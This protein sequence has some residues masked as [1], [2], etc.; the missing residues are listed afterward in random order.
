MRYILFTSM[1]A[2][3][4]FFSFQSFNKE[5]GNKVIKREYKIHIPVDTMTFSPDSLY[6]YLIRIGMRYPRI[7]YKQALLESGRFKS[8]LFKNAN[9][10]FGMRMPN[11]RKTTAISK[12][13]GYAKFSCWKHSVDDY[14]LY[15]DAYLSSAKTEEQYYRLLDKKYGA[16]GRYSYT[17]K[18]MSDEVLKKNQ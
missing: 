5:R 7:V 11:V 4:L 8:D 13:K 14:K 1:I 12:Y 15:Q 9:N 17:L 3:T 2:G 16:A 6:G 18:R 10:L